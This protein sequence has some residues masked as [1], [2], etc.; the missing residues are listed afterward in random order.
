MTKAQEKASEKLA[1][2]LKVETGNAWRVDYDNISG[3]AVMMCGDFPG[4]WQTCPTVARD[5]FGTVRVNPHHMDREHRKRLGMYKGLGWQERAAKD[6][7]K[8]LP[9]GEVK[10]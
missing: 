9:I 3:E 7:A 5:S 4:G 6:A 8:W 2:A 10:P 1:E